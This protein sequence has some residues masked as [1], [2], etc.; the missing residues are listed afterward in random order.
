MCRNSHSRIGI[1]TN[2]SGNSGDIWSGKLPTCT[3][4]VWIQIYLVSADLVWSINLFF[5][6]WFSKNLFL[7]IWWNE[8]SILIWRLTRDFQLQVIFVNHFPLCFLVSHWDHFKV[9][10]KFKEILATLCL[11]PVSTTPAISCSPAWTTPAINIT[12]VIVLGD[13]C[14]ASVNET[15]DYTLYQIFINHQQYLLQVTTTPLK[16]CRWWHQLATHLKVNII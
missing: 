8:K 16:I 7:S 1:P 13:K 3:G 14:I 4:L 5:S 15:S 12:S 6:I 9:I 2:P 11:S 10:H